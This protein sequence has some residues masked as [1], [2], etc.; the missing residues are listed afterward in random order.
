MLDIEKM[1]PYIYL[2]E[3]RD[4]QLYSR[5]LELVINS[6]KYD[7][8]SIT[9][10]YNPQLCN[11]RMLD[12]LCSIYNF[13][14]RNKYTDEDLR[15]ILAG[16]PYLIKYKGTQKGIEYAIALVLKAQNLENE[17]FVNIIRKN[18]DTTKEYTIQIGTLENINETYLLDLLDY[19]KP[20]GFKTEILQ[21]TKEMY[22]SDI[23]TTITYEEDELAKES[24][25]EIQYSNVHFV[26]IGE[27]F[28]PY[29][30]VMYSITHEVV[31]YDKI[32]KIHYIDENSNE[33]YDEG[34]EYNIED[35]LFRYSYGGDIIAYI[36]SYG[37]EGNI[38]RAEIIKLEDIEVE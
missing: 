20:V 17:Y 23:R 19:V 7:I 13:K 32:L 1:V 18:D 30:G 28:F 8:D 35:G 36:P 14:N 26:I 33:V 16:F 11:D 24:T 27:H 9:N 38:N 37:T 29:N 5:L 10:I 31:L 22:Q 12:L 3:S 34:E 15:I 21:I 6:V 2:K 25:G 4:F